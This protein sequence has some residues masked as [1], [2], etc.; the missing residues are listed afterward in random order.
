VPQWRAGTVSDVRPPITP[1]SILLRPTGRSIDHDR[2]GE[3]LHHRGVPMRFPP[4]T[5][6]VRHH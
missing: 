5:S 4:T 2:I 3:L 6:D 1:E